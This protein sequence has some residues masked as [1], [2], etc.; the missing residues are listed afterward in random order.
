M[1]ET[2]RII[3]NVNDTQLDSADKKTRRLR[4]SSGRLRK[5]AGALAKEFTTLAGVAIAGTFVAAIFKA[6]NIN[7]EFEQS[8]ASLKSITGVTT[9]ELKEYREEA[10]RIGRETGKSAIEVVDS[11][12]L[13]GSAQP[14]LLESKEALVAVTEEAITLSK[15]A[16]I[17]VPDA[18]KALTNSL[19][20]FQIPAA[21][22]RDVID[23]LAN[24][25]LRGAAAIPQINE[26]L[27]QFGSVAASNNVSL[28]QS[29][30]LIETLSQ[31][32]I[33]GAEAGT[34]LRNV[35]LILSEDQENYTD[36]VFD[37]NLALDRLNEQY[38]NG[39]ISTKQFGREN[40]NAAQALARNRDRY[41]ELLP[42][43]DESGTATKQA[44]TNT[45]TL[46]GDIDK[47]SASL[48]N[49]ATAI[50]STGVFRTLVQ[51]T[52]DAINA[53]SDVIELGARTVEDN[54][55]DQAERVAKAFPDAFKEQRDSFVTEFKNF[56]NP[57]ISINAEIARSFEDLQRFNDKDFYANY[58]G[59]TEELNKELNDSFLRH[60]ALV[61]AQQILTEELEKNKDT[62]DDNTDSL[63]K[64]NDSRTAS[65]GLIG[66]QVAK[67]KALNEALEQATTTEQIIRIRAQI[68]VEEANL[69]TLTEGGGIELD[70]D[71]P[72]DI[73]D[74]ERLGA[75][76]FSV[77][78]SMGEQLAKGIVERSKQLVSE[79]PSDFVPPANEDGE[80]R[81]EIAELAEQYGFQLANTISIGIG[82]Q[83]EEQIQREIDALNERYDAEVEAAGE[84]EAAIRAINE[85]R[86]QEEKRLQQQIFEERKRTQIRSILISSSQAAVR[87]LLLPPTPGANFG[88]AAAALAFGFAQAALARGFAE[89]VIDLDGPGTGTSDSIPARLSKG[90]SVMTAQ[91]TR[92]YKPALEAI[93]ERK[94]APGVL[95][96]FVNNSQ[97]QVNVYPSD[98]QVLKAIKEQPHYSTMLDEHGFSHY[99]IRAN[100]RTEL[101]NRRH[102]G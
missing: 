4:K 3:Y 8:L 81:D 7:K 41:R 48:E 30:A 89:G 22:A 21:K 32:A 97:P 20:Q 15:A 72:T 59:S 101:K 54:I 2:I 67:I 33:T 13:I 25:S 34:S 14:E 37:L 96:R 85:R 6:I 66:M 63:N 88:A 99:M 95:N 73:L 57:I 42:L 70:A 65:L 60:Q 58:Q 36:G 24:G 64:N 23:A 12:K 5:E 61:D 49:L 102:H 78:Q 16:E 82:R 51:G 44:A 19:N 91:E 56:T 45:D 18:A 39:E 52:A 68:E 38:I 76:A 77:G 28:Q 69:E 86:A 98:E 50:E 1:A 29:V 87:A 80:P 92:M 71:V 17:S 47:L 100:K 55:K 43:I 62:T 40:I 93:R 26:S 84:N 53:I 9:E 94:I 74:A 27:N 46:T 90:E 31:N 83:R 10:R 35:I 75:E 11:F 79:T